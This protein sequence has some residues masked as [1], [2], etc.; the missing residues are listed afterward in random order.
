M[1]EELKTEE[2]ISTQTDSKET[3][4]TISQDKL[5]HLINE[6]FKK[7]ASKATNDLLESLGVDSVETLKNALAK[8]KEAE[9]ASKTELQKAQELAESLKQEKEALANEFSTIQKKNT[10]AQTA[11]KY[12]VKEVDYF[13][14]EYNKAQGQD[15]F[16]LDTFVAGLKVSKPSLFGDTRAPALNTDNS[17]NKG[18]APTLKSKL[19]GLSLQELIK[20]QNTL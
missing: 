3:T 10:L 18:D 11:I 15:G 2:T 5:D 14:L 20:L 4:V 12:G 16:D 6:K 19:Q 17:G 13:E 1:A 9:E 7:G 8:Q